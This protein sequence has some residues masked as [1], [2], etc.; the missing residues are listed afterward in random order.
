MSQPVYLEETSYRLV[1]RLTFA[2]ERIA[3]K[4]EEHVPPAHNTQSAA[5]AKIA[6]ELEAGVRIA[7]IGG[8]PSAEQLHFAQRSRYSPEVAC[9]E[10]KLPPHPHSS[11]RKG[12]FMVIGGEMSA[13]N[14]NVDLA[15]GA[16]P[17]RSPLNTV[18]APLHI[19]QQ[20]QPESVTYCDN[21]FCVNWDCGVCELDQC[22]FVAA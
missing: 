13:S 8:A 22:H 12:A 4:I 18:E 7:N 11:H 20:A 2:A 10:L 21:R 17:V 19:A 1:E 14:G 16:T 15:T 9:D 3:D 5:I 6:A